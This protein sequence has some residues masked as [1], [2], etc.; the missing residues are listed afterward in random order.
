MPHISPY[1]L[2]SSSHHIFGPRSAL[3]TQRDPVKGFTVVLPQTHDSLIEPHTLG[4]TRNPENGSYYHD[5]P[6][7]SVTGTG[8]E[9]GGDKMDRRVGVP[10]TV[11]CK[12]QV[13]ERLMLDPKTADDCLKRDA[14]K[15]GSRTLSARANVSA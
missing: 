8:Q 11:E 14:A 1:S 12:L 5:L 6:P 9:F 2:S 4:F 10:L 7:R 15:L 13:K 3:G